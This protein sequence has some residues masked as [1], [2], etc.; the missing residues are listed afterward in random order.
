ME[1]EDGSDEREREDKDDKRISE[2][3]GEYLLVL[4]S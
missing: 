2:N 3:N 4:R 1:E